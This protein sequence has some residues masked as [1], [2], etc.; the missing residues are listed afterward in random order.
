MGSDDL[1]KK[2]R[3]ERDRLGLKML[4]FNALS[5]Y[6]EFNPEKDNP[7]TTVH[8]LVQELNKQKRP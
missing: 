4:K 7:S 5:S 1:H 2:K 3:S 8:L 6:T